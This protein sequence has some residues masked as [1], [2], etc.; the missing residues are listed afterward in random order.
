MLRVIY[1]LE[2]LGSGDINRPA[3]TQ[4][5]GKSKL[6]GI[7]IGVANGFHARNILERLDVSLLYL[8]DP[9]KEY[10]DNNNVFSQLAL[11][12]AKANAVNVLSNYIN[13]I[14]WL[15]A[16]SENVHTNFDDKSIDFVYIDG[17]HSYNNIK[18]DIEL[19]Y[20]KVKIGG[21]IGGHDY[22]KLQYGIK[23]AVIEF[24]PSSDICNEKNDWWAI[25]RSNN[26]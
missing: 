17:D 6:I 5:I 19:Y 24:F 16:R 22:T 12:A 8:I 13:K 23:Q 21:L 18:K 9:Y 26:E 20:S 1:D 3:I 11:T 15:Y 14:E 10:I 4:L 7:E 25:K 2:Q